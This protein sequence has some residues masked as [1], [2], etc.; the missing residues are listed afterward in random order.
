[1]TPALAITIAAIV[2]AGVAG[3]F[4][5]L[6]WGRLALWLGSAPFAC[7][8]ILALSQ[9]GVAEPFSAGQMWAWCSVTFWPVVG[10][11]AGEVRRSMHRTR[12]DRSNRI[13]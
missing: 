9:G 5:N 4:V 10:C 12:D 7:V 11:A 1:M 13:S 2:A 3:V 8:G 6:W